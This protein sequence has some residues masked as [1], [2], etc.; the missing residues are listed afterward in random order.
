MAAY[1][2]GGKL[3]AM[4]T[5]HPPQAERLI[6]L[7]VFR[8]L[9]LAGMILVNNPGNWEHVYG[10]L[11]HARWHG[12]TVT[13]LVFPSFLFI[14]G[15]AITLAFER[16]I[17]RGDSRWLLF[18]HAIR[19][20]V[21]IFALGMMLNT[22][23]NGYVNGL[24]GGM[25]H[26]GALVPFVLTV[27]GLGVLWPDE[28]AWSRGSGGGAALRLILAAFVVLGA[29]FAFLWYLEDLSASQ[30]RIPGVLQRIAVC[31][32]IAALVVLATGVPGRVLVAVAC[33]V[34]YWAILWRVPAPAGYAAPVT[35]SEGLLHDWLDAK[36]LG[37][38][39]YRE[40]PDPEG[41]LSTLPAVGTVLIGV[42]AGNWLF[43]RRDTERK[44]A[45]LFIAGLAL[46]IG[47]LVADHWM[48][49]NKKIWTSS[50]VLLAGGFCLYLLGFCY[51]FVDLQGIRRWAA[52]FL[53]LGTNAILVYVLSS[54]TGWLLGVTWHLSNGSE[55][56]IKRTVYEALAGQ[57]GP[58]NGSLL[59]A[60]LYVLLWVVLF[61]PLYRARVFIRV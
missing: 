28:S 29:V 4:T 16:R 41:L 8:G 39:V 17:D 61:T 33:L 15:V 20:A 1:N 54:A 36:V 57:V 2:A 49:I 19:R 6:S 47:G 27:L 43:T 58:R 56:N 23:T 26:W 50:Y 22:M 55:L 5:T 21:V 9:T 32:L 59:Y 25:A 60:L 13:D 24:N 34:G 42:L 44:A 37:P 38:H 52:P 12:W 10:P 30:V 48:P 18:S 14:V 31:Y 53:V 40:R 46:T 11:R 51:L 7:D 45:G 35:G 3:S